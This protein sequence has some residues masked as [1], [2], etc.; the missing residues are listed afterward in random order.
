MQF[1]TWFKHL[2]TLEIKDKNILPKLYFTQYY[3]DISRKVDSEGSV[4]WLRIR[5]RFGTRS[6]PGLPKK[7]G[8]DRI[9]IRNTV[10]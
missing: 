2:M 9:R 4:C 10:L 6:S 3:I 7:I 8:S 5:I 1:I